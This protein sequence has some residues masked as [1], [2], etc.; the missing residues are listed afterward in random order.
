MLGEFHP[1]SA[2]R[3][4]Y[5][6][7]FRAMRA[8][9]PLFAVRAISEHD[10]KFLIRPEFPLAERLECLEALLAF[11]GDELDRKTKAGI[12]TVVSGLKAKSASKRK[13]LEGY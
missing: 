8:P 7:A 6:P 3:G 11:F 13:Y 12:E 10:Q 9:M 5:N 1:Q 4:I 2:V